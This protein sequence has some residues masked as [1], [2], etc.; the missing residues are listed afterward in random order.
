MFQRSTQSARKRWLPFLLRSERR[1]LNRLSPHWT[2]CFSL[3]PWWHLLDCSCRSCCLNVVC[4]KRLPRRPS[5]TS[6]AIL[7]RHMQ[8]LPTP[9][10]AHIYCVDLPCSLIEL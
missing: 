6:A 7:H 10:R 2:A 1:T 3:P 9:I 5:Q 4:E 8:C